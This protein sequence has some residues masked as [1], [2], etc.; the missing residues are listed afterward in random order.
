LIEIGRVLR[1]SGTL[2]I[3]IVHPLAA[4]GRFAGL[5]PDAPFVVSGSYFAGERFESVEERNGLQMHFAGWSRSLETYMAALKDAGFAVSALREPVPDVNAAWDP[6]EIERW[7]KIPLFL[8]LKGR[9][10]PL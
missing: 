5:G 7:S 8:W 9:P 3:S 10:L 4:R 2:I 1:P 6:I